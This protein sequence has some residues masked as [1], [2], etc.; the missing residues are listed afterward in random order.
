[1]SSAIPTAKLYEACPAVS[2]VKFTSVLP[3]PLSMYALNRCIS[4]Y[5]SIRNGSYCITITVFV[6]TCYNKCISNTI[7]VYHLPLGINITAAIMGLLFYRLNLNWKLGTVGP[8]TLPSKYWWNVRLVILKMQ[9]FQY[10]L[11]VNSPVL[12]TYI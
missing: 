12:S 6:A 9:F 3:L 4:S 2:V 8:S 10:H 11:L 5:K 7:N 1:M